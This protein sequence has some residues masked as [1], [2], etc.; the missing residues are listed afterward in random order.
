M[1]VSHFGSLAANPRVINGQLHFCT[2]LTCRNTHVV[3]NEWLNRLQCFM[4]HCGNIVFGLYACV[5]LHCP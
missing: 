3:M 1:E 4:V 5:L 2:F